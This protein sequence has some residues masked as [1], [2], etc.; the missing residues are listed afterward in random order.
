MYNHAPK[1][2][3]CPFCLIVKGVENEHAYTKQSDII[4]KDKYVAAWVS[5]H[6]WLPKNKAHII[7]TTNKHIENIYDLPL[8]LSNKVHALE[9]Q[10]ALALKKVYKCDGVSSRQHNEQYGDQ[11]IWHYKNDDLYGPN[12]KRSLS[13]PKDRKSY[14]EKL[15]RYFTK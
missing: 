9:K 1:N 10:V 8:N 13:N 3:K 15:K 6:W 12:K 11:D 4:Y 7:V 14:A 5:A 2:Y